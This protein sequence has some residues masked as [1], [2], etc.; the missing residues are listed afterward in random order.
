MV[1]LLLLSRCLRFAG[2]ECVEKVHEYPVQMLPSVAA[3]ME[4]ARRIVRQQKLERQERQS[5]GYPLYLFDRA[6]HL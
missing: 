1:F 6:S 2:R 5:T 4:R 3:A